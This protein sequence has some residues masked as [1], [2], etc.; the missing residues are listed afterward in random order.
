MALVNVFGGGSSP[1]GSN[2]GVQYNDAG[3]F[4]ASPDLKFDGTNKILRL[5][6]E[7]RISAKAGVDSYNADRNLIYSRVFSVKMPN[8]LTGAQEFISLQLVHE[9]TGVPINDKWDMI[10]YE[11]VIQGARNGSGPCTEHIRGYIKYEGNVNALTEGHSSIYSE[12]TV[13]TFSVVITDAT[14]LAQF[15][16]DP[17]SGAGTDFG[18]GIFV[19]FFLNR[20]LV[21]S[22]D[23]SY[24][25]FVWVIASP[26]S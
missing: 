25:D 3:S 11:V 2:Q 19:K 24:Q 21:G 1:G 17:F 10:T 26:L 16:V 15:K 18:G 6:G 14:A 22:P 5:Q 8:S 23:D 7:Q 9:T 20:G 12:G 13:P 4:G